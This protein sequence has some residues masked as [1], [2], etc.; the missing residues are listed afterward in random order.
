MNL[1][2]SNTSN[3]LNISSQTE[4]YSY[5]STV[6]E[7]LLVQVRLR[8]SSIVGN[9]TYTAKAYIGGTLIAPVSAFNVPSGE[10]SFF[11]MSKEI[12]LKTGEELTVEL[13]GQVADTAAIVVAELY[14]ITPVSETQV[15]GSGATAVDHNFPNDDDMTIKLSDGTPVVGACIYIYTTADYDGGNRE[16]QFIVGQSLTTTGGLWQRPVMLDPGDYTAVVFKQGVMPPFTAEFTV[17]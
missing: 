14:D 13:Q 8:I 15:S 3:P 1:L 9:G 6:A 10:T 7:T 2:D 4:A 5:L 12:I 17:P 16:P 11:V